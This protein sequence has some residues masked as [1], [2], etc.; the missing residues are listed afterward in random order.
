M[1]LMPAYASLTPPFYQDGRR[2]SSR[3]KLRLGG[4]E[5]R[6]DRILHLFVRNPIDLGFCVRNKRKT[7]NF[8]D[9]INLIR[10]P[11]PPQSYA[12]ARLIEQAAKGKM[13]DAFSVLRPRKLV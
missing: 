1:R 9:R 10:L 12:D 11:R 7:E 5:L 13:Q 3:R 6:P 8:G 2:V 4:H